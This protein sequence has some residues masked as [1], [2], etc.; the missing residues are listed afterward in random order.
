MQKEIA[1]IQELLISRATGSASSEEADEYLRLRKLL[2][3]DARIA[4]LLPPWIKDSRTLDQFWP[5]IKHRFPTYADRREFIW[6]EFHLVE[7]H[8]DGNTGSPSDADV[9]MAIT[10][11]DSAHVQV[12]WQKA[13]ERRASDPEGAI[14]SARTLLEAV[15]KHIL[16]ASGTPYDDAA[17]MNT[18]YR[19]TAKQL[20]LAPTRIAA[21]SA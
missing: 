3:A 10:K 12:A 4:F 21:Q 14:T 7:D 8:L 13:L 20:K 16:D 5:Y 9:T 2:L 1:K 11:F 15:C 6:K 17:D 19:L 18:L